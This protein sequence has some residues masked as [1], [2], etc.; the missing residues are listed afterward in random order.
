MTDK[1]WDQKR[2]ASCE[3]TE[4]GDLVSRIF[5]VCL[6]VHKATDITLLDGRRAPDQSVV[7]TQFKSIG[8]DYLNV[9]LFC[10]GRKV[11]GF[12]LEG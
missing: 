4:S 6:F 12:A 8:L 9:M 11:G 5:F 1:N 3:E 7:K 2:K 10:L